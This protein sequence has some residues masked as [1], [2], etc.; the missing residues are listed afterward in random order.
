[1]AFFHRR[2]CLFLP[3]LE[4]TVQNKQS[5][6]IKGCLGGLHG[7]MLHIWNFSY[8]YFILLPLTMH[9]NTQQKKSH[10]ALGQWGVSIKN[11]TSKLSLSLSSFKWRH[12]WKEDESMWGGCSV[13]SYKHKCNLPLQT[14]LSEKSQKQKVWRYCQTIFPESVSIQKNM[15]HHFIWGG[16]WI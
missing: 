8:A 1:M 13:Q 16:I 12:M 15:I 2:L 9:Q 6:Q 7:H 10:N 14:W 3:I 5:C 4:G 11:V